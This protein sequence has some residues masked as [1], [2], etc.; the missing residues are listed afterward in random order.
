VN[1]G[2]RLL[3]VAR[4]LLANRSRP[5]IERLEREQDPE[6][7]LWLVLP[8]AARTFSLAIAALPARLARPIGVAYLCCRILD[9]A[10]DL[11]RDPAE[12]DALLD[13]AVALARDGVPMPPVSAPWVQDARD[14][15][16]LVLVSRSDLV[17][18]LL[19]SVPGGARFRTA[20]LVDRMAA[21]MKRAAQVR[22]R[23]SGVVAGEERER[24]CRAV[25]A[26]PL[27]FAEGELRE[28]VGLDPALAADRRATIGDVGE[29][30][31]LANVCRDVEKDLA[32]RVAYDPA[33]E[34]WLDAGKAPVDVVLGVR[35]RILERVSALAPAIEPFFAG[36]PFGTISGA[37]GA[38]LVLLITTARFFQRADAGLDPRVLRPARLP[39]RFRAAFACAAA[40]LSG[41][42]ARRAAL[43]ARAA[44]TACPPGGIRL[45]SLRAS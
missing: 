14:R 10:E 15:A 8:H 39:A 29:L 31:Q 23:T 6:R 27:A 45:E 11:A 41:A 20:A 24:Y 35:R 19:A 16:H 3:R 21:G 32:R 12:R 4:N 9:T 36:L 34:P 26:E 18:K 33:L 43:R 25:L 44:L 22:A 5:P 1:R 38:A 42:S 7:F 40:I 30:I 17:A 13:A 28:A 2:R 37:R